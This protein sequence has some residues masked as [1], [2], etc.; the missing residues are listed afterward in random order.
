MLIGAEALDNVCSVPQRCSHICQDTCKQKQTNTLSELVE[1]VY[2]SQHFYFFNC[3]N[4][5]LSPEL[6]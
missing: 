6:K 1:V 4:V 3:K 5:P 2:T